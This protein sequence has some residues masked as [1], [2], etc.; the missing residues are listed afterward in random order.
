MNKEQNSAVV[1][2][3]RE[4]ESLAEKVRKDLACTRTHTMREWAII[5]AAL[6]APVPPADGTPSREIDRIRA[7]LKT[8]CNAGERCSCVDG[9]W[10]WYGANC[11]ANMTQATREALASPSGTGATEPVARDKN[12]FSQLADEPLAV[13]PES[14]SAPLHIRTA[15]EIEFARKAAK[16]ALPPVRED[17]EAIW[18]LNDKQLWEAN[19]ITRTQLE[20]LSDES[21]SKHAAGM[22]HTVKFL[23]QLLDE[24]SLS[25]KGGSL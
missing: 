25:H 19:C 10:Q 20:S 24:F 23:M 18:P 13:I 9:N 1:P 5:E 11:A 16:G 21:I 14:Y 3:T 6:S 4:R 17:R 7:K 8:L 12:M 2:G 15:A 22:R